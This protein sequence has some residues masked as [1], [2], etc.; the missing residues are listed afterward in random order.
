MAGCSS[1]SS[2]S[3]TTSPP[4]TANPASGD[5]ATSATAA[6]SGATLTACPT[7]AVVS[8]AL[9][10]AYPAPQSSSASGELSCNDNDPNTSANAVLGFSKAPGLTLAV[11]KSTADGQAS[12]QSVTAS[13]VSGLG[14]GA[15]LFTLNDASTNSSGVATT[16]LL[17][18][19]G[20]TLVDIT[21]EATPA[22]VQA[23]GHALVP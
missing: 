20:A 3:T 10:S 13:P 7:A 1:A 19:S 21:A 16:T 12:A 11:L 18:K 6:S 15:Y 9:G 22:Q 17:I 8:A 4:T 14:D 2:S 5:G 23:L